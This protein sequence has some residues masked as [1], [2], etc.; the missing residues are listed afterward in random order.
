MHPNVELLRLER[1]LHEAHDRLGWINR[2]VP[3]ATARRAA[4]DLYAEAIAAVGAYVASHEAPQK[5]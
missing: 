2:L 3:D 5:N 1:A 4:E